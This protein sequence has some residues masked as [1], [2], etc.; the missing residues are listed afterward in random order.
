MNEKTTV[1][2]REGAVRPVWLLITDNMGHPYTFGLT[3]KE[4][5][6]LREQLDAVYRKYYAWD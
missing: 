1:A 2:F 5:E 3:E 6:V 4:F